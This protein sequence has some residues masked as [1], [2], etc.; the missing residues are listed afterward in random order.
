[1]TATEETALPADPEV[2][3]TSST[4]DNLQTAVSFLQ[5]KFVPTEDD[6]LNAFA[7]GTWTRSKDDSTTP[8]PAPETRNA[9]KEEDL[10]EAGAI[11]I[12]VPANRIL[13]DIAENIEY[14][15]I[16]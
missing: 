13:V 3:G 1:M 9:T 5:P 14:N 6:A 4:K 10:I 15:Y 16:I 8:K 2:C 7:T 11:A 12:I